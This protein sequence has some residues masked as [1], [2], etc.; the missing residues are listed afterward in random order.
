MSTQGIIADQGWLPWQWNAFKTPFLC[1]AFFTYFIAAL[2]EGNRTPFDLPEGESELVAGYNTEYSGMRFAIFFLAEWANLYVIAAIATLAFLGGWNV[3]GFI[4]GSVSPVLQVLFFVG[5]SF[6]MVFVIIWIR[7]TLPRV[8][9][10]QMMEVCWKYL[11]P[12]SFVTILGT[13]TWVALVPGDTA[14]ARGVS[15]ALFLIGVF[16]GVRFILRVRYN[17]QDT[18]AKLHLSPFV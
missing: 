5:K 13:A 9:V 2:G 18:K 16:V 12:V 17:L 7:W 3:P 14:L 1:V 8:R 4:P 10:D 15:I 6:L 11:V